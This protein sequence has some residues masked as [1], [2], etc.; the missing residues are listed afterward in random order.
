MKSLGLKEVKRAAKLTIKKNKIDNKIAKLSKQYICLINP[1]L[2][3]DYFNAL[4][5]DYIKHHM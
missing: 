2:D 4:I 1:K 3:E 5:N